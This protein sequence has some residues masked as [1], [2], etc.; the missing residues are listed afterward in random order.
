MVIISN[1]IVVTTNIIIDSYIIWSYIIWFCTYCT[2]PF[3]W[4][5]FSSAKKVFDL[6]HHPFLVPSS[7]V[8]PPSVVLYCL[9]RSRCLRYHPVWFGCNAVLRSQRKWCF[10]LFHHVFEI[11]QRTIF[12]TRK[13][14][15]HNSEQKKIHLGFKLYELTK[16][17]SNMIFSNNL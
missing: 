15:R 17:Q 13:R 11:I 8:L 16:L 4:I 6:F 9:L 2:V 3:S 7:S 5:G 1:I 10:H 12:F 14:M